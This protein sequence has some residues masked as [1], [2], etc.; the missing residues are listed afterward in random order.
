M[1]IQI[2]TVDR[3]ILCIEPFAINFQDEQNSMSCNLTQSL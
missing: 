2:L 1:I 3:G